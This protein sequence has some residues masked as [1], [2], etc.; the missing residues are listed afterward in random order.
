M[1][2]Y[3]VYNLHVCSDFEIPELFSWPNGCQEKADLCISEGR[4]SESQKS[5]LS[6]VGPFLFGDEQTV[7]LTVPDIARFLV[8]SGKNIVYQKLGNSRDD[9]VRVFLLG[10]C[11]GAILIQRGFLVL[12]GCTVKIG[13][14]CVVCVGHSTV[15]KSTL[16]AAFMRKGYSLMSDDVCAINENGE[17]IPSIPRIKL[18]KNM[19]DLLEINTG[20]LKT[21]RAACDSKFSLPLGN[22]FNDTNLPVYAVYELSVWSSATTIESDLNKVEHF[23]LLNRNLYRPRY[24][25]AMN[26]KADGFRQCTE[27]VG[28]VHMAQLKRPMHHVSVHDLLEL[29]INDLKA[30]GLV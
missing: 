4:I 19:A 6:Q 27:L 5:G 9:D 23:S 26:K 7:F 10:S 25:M 18:N 28:N 13:Q 20:G 3:T 14:G 1:Y 12:H 29:I 2:F 22:K 17:A 11:L 24:L 21:I 15:G 30:Q 8:Q 16:A